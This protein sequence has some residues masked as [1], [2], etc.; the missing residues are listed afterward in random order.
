LFQS[1]SSLQSQCWKRTVAPCF[2]Q[3]IYFC[4]IF[5]N[6]ST[7]SKIRLL[8]HF[9]RVGMISRWKYSFWNPLFFHTFSFGAHWS[10][11]WN[12]FVFIVILT[13]PREFMSPR[14]LSYLSS[15][16]L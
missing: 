5:Q 9:V 1:F 10:S 4:S 15:H 11:S 8:L 3:C 12:L 2:R 6:V 14:T 7:L 13:I 16:F